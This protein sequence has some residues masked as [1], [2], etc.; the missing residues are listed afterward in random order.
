M[1]NDLHELVAHY[2]VDPDG[3][4]V[5]LRDACRPLE[6]PATADLSHNTK[7]QVRTTTR[8]DGRVYGTDS[9]RPKHTSVESVREEDTDME[10]DRK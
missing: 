9:V 3:L 10:T 7:D 8:R 5:A 6:Q 2:K 4:C 1:F